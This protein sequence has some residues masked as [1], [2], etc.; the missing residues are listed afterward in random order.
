MTSVSR[1]PRTTRFQMTIHLAALAPLASLLWDTALGKLP[2]D[3]GPALIARTGLIAA[4]F[5]VLSLA[6]TPAYIVTGFKRVRNARRALGLYAFFYAA[7][8]FAAYAWLRYGWDLYQIGLDI[9]DRDAAK[10]G[11]VALLILTLLAITSTKGWQRRLRKGWIRLHKLA[12]VSAMLVM[13]HFIWVREEDFRQPLAWTGFLFLLFVV[14]LPTIRRW[15]T[16]RR[17]TKRVVASSRRFVGKM[18]ITHAES[19]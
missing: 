10:F 12:Y 15:F 19:A 1:K 4:L 17:N 16:A 13:L 3:P 2:A 6:V 11:V 5:L 8:H 14:R 9:A 18:Q 7:L